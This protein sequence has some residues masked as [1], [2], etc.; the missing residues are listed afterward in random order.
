MME[1]KSLIDFMNDKQFELDSY[2][3]YLLEANQEDA[4]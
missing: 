2:L 1:D 4:L 3:N